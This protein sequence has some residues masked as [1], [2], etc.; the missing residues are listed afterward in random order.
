M[1]FSKAIEL[2][3]TAVDNLKIKDQWGSNLPP[4]IVSGKLLNEFPELQKANDAFYEN[5]IKPEE[6][7]SA[8]YQY[9][10][11]YKT[12]RAAKKLDEALL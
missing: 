2:V 6:W 5:K 9:V 3:E 4:I 11:L 8:W 12:I 10:E 7:A 1:E